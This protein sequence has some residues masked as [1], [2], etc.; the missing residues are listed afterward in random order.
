[1][2]EVISRK[3]LDL[4]LSEQNSLAT[5]SEWFTPSSADF[6]LEQ[7][8][9]QGGVLLPIRVETRAVGSTYETGD[10][11]PIVNYETLNT[12]NVG[13]ISFY[14]DPMRLVFRDTLDYIGNQEYRII[15]ESDF[16][17]QEFA[18]ESIA[19]LP[20]YFASLVEI[21]A[22]WE[23]LD[24]VAD[25]SPEWQ[26]FYDIASA[27]WPALIADRR[28]SF[29]KY[30]RMFKGRAQVP[31]RSFFQNQRERIQTRYFRG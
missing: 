25:E 26:K 17:E 19:G 9:L 13:A 2:G 8:G 24:Q 15:Y 11:V 1:M 31:K 6:P 22:A 10:N 12:S 20:A 4:A 18:L 5:T 16:D 28:A 30:V 7:L 3:K 27:K 29:D 21:E 14:G 23:L